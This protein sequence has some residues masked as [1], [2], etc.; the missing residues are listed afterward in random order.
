M[1]HDNTCHYAVHNDTSR[2]L[3]RLLTV[4]REELSSMLFPK[5]SKHL[6]PKLNIVSE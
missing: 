3:I 4:F 5:F 1:V 2:G 6:L